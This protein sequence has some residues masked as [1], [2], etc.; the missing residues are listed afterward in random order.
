MK[1][2]SFE[3]QLGAE[4]PEDEWENFGLWK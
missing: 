1:A 4:I 2:T 3:F